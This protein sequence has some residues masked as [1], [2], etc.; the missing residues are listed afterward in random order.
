MKKIKQ[1]HGE[2]N[3]TRHSRRARLWVHGVQGKLR[4]NKK[5]KTKIVLAA[6]YFDYGS[7]INLLCA[8]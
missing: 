7:L 5:L 1:L 3:L 8:F 2:N 6:L 4:Q